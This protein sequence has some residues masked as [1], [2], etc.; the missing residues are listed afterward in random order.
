MYFMQSA[1]RLRKVLAILGAAVVIV[2]GILVSGSSSIHSSPAAIQ[3]TLTSND[4]P[5]STLRPYMRF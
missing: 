1:L 5:G 2:A 4:G 3:A